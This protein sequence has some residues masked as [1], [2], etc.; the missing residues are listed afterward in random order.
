MVDMK[1]H[2]ASLVAVFLALGVGILV[3]SAL[4]TDSA[5]VERQEQM[6]DR[7]EEDFA[8]MRAEKEDLSGRLAA[9]Q[10]LLAAS[11]EFEES[12]ASLLVRGR[13]SG[14]RV[15]IAVCHDAMSPEEVEKICSILEDAGA[16]VARVVYVNKDLVPAAG[17]DAREAASLF[18]LSETESDLIGL[19]A[20]RALA[21]Y[22]AFHEASQVADALFLWGYATLRGQ[23]ELLPNDSADAVVVVVGSS[24][25]A[26]GPADAGIPMVRALKDL[27]V[28]VVGAESWDVKVSHIA[29][30]RREG[31]PTVDCADVPLGRLLLVHAL[32]VQKGNFGIKGAS[33]TLVPE[34]WGIP[35]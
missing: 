20:A 6:I 23:E 32:A 7:L 4:V 18:G 33:E 12:A 25:P 24:D 35:Q 3:G 16:R 1:Y 17:T 26:S 8:R 28:E 30:Y 2:L 21:A 34:M 14:K 9:S 15:A 19:E 29:D 31:I 10:R 13:L 22:L 5:L 27:G 11:L